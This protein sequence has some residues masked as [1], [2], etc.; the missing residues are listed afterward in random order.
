MFEK[1]LPAFGVVGIVLLIGGHFFVV[2]EAAARKDALT[3][4]NTATWDPE[5]L[6][7]A[8]QTT[9]HPNGAFATISL[10]LPPKNSS[11]ETR[12]ELAA[13]L[14]HQ[15]A[16]ILKEVADIVAENGLSTTDFGGHTLTA[17]MDATQFP[18]TALLLKDSY[19]DLTV[20][21][22]Q[23]KRKFDRV[24]PNKL[25]SALTPAIEVP[26]HPSYPSGHST[27]LHFFAHVFGELAPARKEEFLARADHIAKNREVA[28]LHYP[29]DTQAGILLAQQFFAIMLENPKFQTLVAGAKEEWRQKALN[30]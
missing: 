14:M 17:Y 13:L 25:D 19:R 15:K 26:G 5:Y 22:M 12:S 28:G 11:S 9:R 8:E 3:F 18:A 1:Y 29:S 7:L 23:E 4:S 24:R 20:I 30:F 10:P 27:Q 21:T 16:R 2:R 6:A